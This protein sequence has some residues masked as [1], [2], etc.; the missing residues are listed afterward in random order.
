MSVVVLKWACT[1][2][3][4]VLHPPKY[5]FTQVHPFSRLTPKFLD[6][7]FTVSATPLHPPTLHHNH[8]CSK[9]QRLLTCSANNSFKQGSPI[10]LSASI[11]S[12]IQCIHIQ[13]RRRGPSKP[14]SYHVTPDSNS[15]MHPNS[16]TVRVTDL[17][18]SIE[19]C[20]IVSPPTP[21]SLS[22]HFIFFRAPNPP[23]T[24]ILQ[25]HWPLW[26]HHKDCTFTLHLF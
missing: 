10:G 7:F 26:F 15:V 1:V 5:A 22:A 12:P 18:Q 14:K 16:F 2:L 19:P 23:D 25:L 24:K 17:M 20:I 21:P 11:F 8:G 9:T 13:R 6:S 4:P 3:T